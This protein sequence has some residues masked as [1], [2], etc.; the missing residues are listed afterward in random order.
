MKTLAIYYRSRA[1]SSKALP[2]LLLL[3]RNSISLSPPLPSSRKMKDCKWMLSPSRSRSLSFFFVYITH[4]YIHVYIVAVFYF[5]ATA[6]P[7]LSSG[8]LYSLSLS[9]SRPLFSEF[10][11][12]AAVQFVILRDDIFI[13]RPRRK[14]RAPA[15]AA[16]LFIAVVVSDKIPPDDVHERDYMEQQKYWPVVLNKLLES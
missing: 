5:P 11:F 6:R 13:W 1:F 8:F 15:R 2:P 16:I 14:S 9:L 12:L 7:H 10:N 4:V 3:P